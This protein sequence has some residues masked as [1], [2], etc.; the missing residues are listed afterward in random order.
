MQQVLEAVVKHLADEV[1][2]SS[3][4]ASGARHRVALRGDG[5]AGHPGCVRSIVLVEGDVSLAASRRVHHDLLVVLH[6][7]RVG[8]LGLIQA[9]D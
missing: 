5:T 3:H 7:A 1:R 6:A 9:L 2:E 4:V 8:V